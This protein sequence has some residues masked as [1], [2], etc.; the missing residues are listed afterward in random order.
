MTALVVLFDNLLI[1]KCVSVPGQ[2]VEPF[3]DYCRQRGVNL[4]GG[5]LDLSFE[6]QFMYI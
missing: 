5:A 6:F 3:A 4:H 1:S 2:L